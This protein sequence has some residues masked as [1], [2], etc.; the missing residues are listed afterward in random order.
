MLNDPYAPPAS[1][2]SGAPAKAA[3]LERIEVTYS[4]TYLDI[5]WD[6]A[7][8]Y[9]R[10]PVLAIIFGLWVSYLSYTIALDEVGNFHLNVFLFSLAEFGG[11]LIGVG[12]IF[13]LLL[14]AFSA[15]RGSAESVFGPYRLEL[16]SEGMTRETS[17]EKLL[18]KWHGIRAVKL[19]P[20]YIRIYQTPSTYYFLPRR[21]FTLEQDVENF[22]LTAKRYL[23]QAKSNTTK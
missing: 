14:T 11:G 20:W 15:M 1:E 3:A 23:D 12:A 8:I 5:V 4:H 18:I 2:V 21:A 17:T 16:A 19:S 6:R 13:T 7:G 22:Y 9:W 10:N